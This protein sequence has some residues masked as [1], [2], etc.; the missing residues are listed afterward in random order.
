MHRAPTRPVFRIRSYPT[1]EKC[2]TGSRGTRPTEHVHLA[3][4]ANTLVIAP[5]T[6]H[7]IIA[8][9]L[10]QINDVRRKHYDLTH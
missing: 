10:L 2:I 5:L 1:I 4:A 9:R 7:E 8:L 3:G 6:K